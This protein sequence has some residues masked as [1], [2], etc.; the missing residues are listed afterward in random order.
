M[1]TPGPFITSDD[2]YQAQSKSPRVIGQMKLSRLEFHIDMTDEEMQAVCAEAKIIRD[3][4]RKWEE[5]YTDLR[6]RKARFLGFQA[7][8]LALDPVQ[9]AAALQT[10]PQL[11]QAVMGQYAASEQ[12][13]LIEL[14]AEYWNAGI[15]PEGSVLDDPSEEVIPDPDPL[16]PPGPI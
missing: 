2:E 4:Y 6:Q 3:T 12:A 10:T 7:V 8:L 5:F 13:R 11:L 16:D 9:T 1:T 14:E 15:L